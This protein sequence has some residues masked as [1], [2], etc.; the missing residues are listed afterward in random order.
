LVS[1]ALI[2]TMQDIGIEEVEFDPKSQTSHNTLSKYFSSNEIGKVTF[3]PY[4]RGESIIIHLVLGHGM[5]MFSVE[6]TLRSFYR[7]I[8]KF[9]WCKDGHATKTL[10]RSGPESDVIYHHRGFDS[11]RRNTF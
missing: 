9:G 8:V 2:L 11:H 10:M 3:C 4:V 7:R 5:T 6:N 1:D